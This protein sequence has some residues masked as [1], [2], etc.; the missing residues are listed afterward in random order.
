LP[1][2]PVPLLDDDPDVPLD[3][4]QVL[5]KTYEG[6]RFDRNVDYQRPPRIRLTPEESV[7]ADERLRAWRDSRS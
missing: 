5:T 1:T 4:Q 7:W 3:L 2:V 6:L